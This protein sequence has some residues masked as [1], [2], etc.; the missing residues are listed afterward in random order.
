MAAASVS[1]DFLSLVERG[2]RLPG[3]TTIEMPEDVLSPPMESISSR[4]PG[5][6]LDPLPHGAHA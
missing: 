5:R 1:V 2:C 3:G 6:Y 4:V